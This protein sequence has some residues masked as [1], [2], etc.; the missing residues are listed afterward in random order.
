[1]RTE[2]LGHYELIEEVGRGGGGTVWKARDMKLDREVAIKILSR[3]ETVDADRRGRFLLEAKAASNLNHPNIVTIH[4]INSDGG[5]DFI[6]MEFVHGTPLSRKITPQG[7]VIEEAVT[8]AAQIASAL[9]N[10]HDAGVVHR[11]VKPSN[12]MVDSEGRVKVLDFGLAKLIEGTRLKVL[13]GSRPDTPRTIRGTIMGTI[14]YMSPEQACG[15]E[16]D[17]RSD[18]FS[19]GTM[20]YEMVT[21]RKP[22]AGENDLSTLSRICSAAQPDPE[23]FRQDIPAPLLGMINRLLEKEPRKRYASMA[24]VACGLQAIRDGR[25]VAADTPTVSMVRPPKSRGRRRWLIPA[26]GL[27]VLLG[28]G[29]PFVVNRVGEWGLLSRVRVTGGGAFELYARGKTALLRYD[30]RENRELAVSLFQQ[31]ARRDPNYALAY[32][33]LAEAMWRQWQENPDPSLL[34]KALESAQLAVRRGGHFAVPHAVLGA[35]QLERADDRSKGIDSLRNAL[36]LDPRCVEANYALARFYAL[37]DNWEQSRAYLARAFEVMPEYWANHCL[38]AFLFH[39]RGQYQA[40]IDSFQEALRLA[41]DN[42]QAFRDLS[43]SYYMAERYE[44]AASALQ[45]SLAIE[46]SHRAYSNLG[47]LRFFQGHYAESASL[48]EKA[49]EMGSTRYQTWGNLAD[50]YRW[51][52][53]MEQK[54]GNAFRVAL[55]LVQQWLEAHPGDVSAKTSMAVYLA[56]TGQPL[57]AVAVLEGLPASSLQ[58]ADIQYKLGVVSELAGR[59]PAALASLER[60]LKIGY[61]VRELEADPELQALRRDPR[62]QLM[63]AR[64]AGMRPN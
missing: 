32:A 14:F 52:P 11:D 7:M 38:R 22:F 31:A 54:S 13:A 10:A 44:D 27:A 59:R 48:M 43:T 55:R 24:D 15:G 39:R 60:C 9:A 51:V 4:E 41:P 40:A 8:I 21:G 56:K 33:G 53:G 20:L 57:E 37:T 2:C 64:S 30:R 42:A 19:F 45:R 5:R 46:P 25:R 63:L 62:Y 17:A 3:E 50:A 6:V 34:A 12:V 29:S 47:T 16:V 49:I 35:I 18:M 36:D 26:V 58:R 61:A 28:V 23:S 1:M